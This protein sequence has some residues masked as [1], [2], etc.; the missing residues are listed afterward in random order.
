[1]IWLSWL[2]TML[3]VVRILLILSGI[4]LLIWL[5]VFFISVLVDKHRRKKYPEYFELFDA[6]MEQASK[7]SAYIEKEADFLE[8]H[9]E[10]L[11]DGLR[12][13]ECTEEYF[14]K[15]FGELSERYSKACKYHESRI[16]QSNILF[17]AADK[18]ARDNDLKWGLL[19]DNEQ[20]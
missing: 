9:F 18:Y 11:R 8:F 3:S 16:K 12:D 1:M 13:G 4:L 7:G 20:E 19:Y 2:D 15:R 5:V 6:A 14:K 17:R 10:M